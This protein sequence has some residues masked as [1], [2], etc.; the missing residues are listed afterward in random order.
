MLDRLRAAPDGARR[1]LHRSPHAVYVDLDGRCVGVV[2]PAAAQVPCALRT[3]T[4]GLE[5]LPARSAEV[6]G[7]VLHL[8]GRPL[9]VGRLV[10]VQVPA[11]PALRGRAVAPAPLDPAEVRAL[12]GAGEGLTPYGDDVLCGWL[13]VHHAAG[14]AAQEVTDAVRALASRTTVLSATLLDC[15]TRGEVLPPFAAWL[16][17]VGT[18][19]ELRAAAALTAVGHTSGRGLLEGARRALAGLDRHVG[20]A[21]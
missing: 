11:L 21:A 9:V 1:V 16:R 8:D 10:D 18:P 6:R 3:G 13:A 15:A 4:R 17:A 2:E 12:V 19:A 5:G 20:A 14:V 7:G